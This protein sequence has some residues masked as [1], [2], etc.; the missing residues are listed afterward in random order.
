M[1]VVNKATEATSQ[2]D[3]LDTIAAARLLTLEPQTLRNW[4]VMGRT[5]LPFIRLGRRSIR[6]RRGDIVA[7]IESGR[8]AEH[9]TD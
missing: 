6:Y 2:Y 1:A 5:D 8:N 3:L 7:F 9:D 4:R